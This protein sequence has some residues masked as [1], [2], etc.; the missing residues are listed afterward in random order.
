MA[1]AVTANPVTTTKV[2]NCAR[3]RGPPRVT[4]ARNITA[5]AP[6]ASCGAPSPSLP[7]GRGTANAAATAVTGNAATSRLS[8]RPAFL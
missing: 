7:A 1:A 6:P 3:R 4:N 5:A 2:A 8:D